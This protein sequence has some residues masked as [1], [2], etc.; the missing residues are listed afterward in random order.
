LADETNLAAEA[1]EDEEASGDARRLIP[2]SASIPEPPLFTVYICMTYLCDGC[3]GYGQSLGV[4][5]QSLTRGKV[6]DEVLALILAEIEVEHSM[7]GCNGTLHRLQLLMMES[8]D[9]F[10]P[11]SFEEPR[12]SWLKG[13]A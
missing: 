10:V 5:R 13:P 6:S 7:T 8:R 11:M 2:L 12:S 4:R 1:Y 3:K 9:S